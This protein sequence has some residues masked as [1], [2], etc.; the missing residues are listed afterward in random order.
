MLYVVLVLGALLAAYGIVSVR[1]TIPD[2]VRRRA[3]RWARRKG[4][5]IQAG[6]RARFTICVSPF[7]AS[8]GQVVEALCAALAGVE[9]GLE[10]I[11]E[12][13]GFDYSS[14]AV[15]PF[16]RRLAS[17]WQES[18][19]LSHR[20]GVF[21]PSEF[22]MGNPGSESMIESVRSSAHGP[23]ARLVSKVI[24]LFMGLT[25]LAA[26]ALPPMFFEGNP[27]FL[28]SRHGDGLGP[29]FR[30]AVKGGLLFRCSILFLA[31][32]EVGTRKDPALAKRRP[33]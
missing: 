8:Q 26:G 23:N 4:P 14:Y 30:L 20:L 1:S 5:R 21:H 13:P 24:W 16:R 31:R 11:V 17:A 18:R 27:L 19:H 6:K 9:E 15:N 28:R 25:V 12:S 29:R 33:A 22:S 2:W 32:S 7:L 3:R 10:G